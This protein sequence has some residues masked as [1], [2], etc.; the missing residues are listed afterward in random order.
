MR[1]VPG[2]VYDSINSME[3]WNDGLDMMQLGHDGIF[4][5]LGIASMDPLHVYV[6]DYRQL[7]P[8]RLLQYITKVST[9]GPSWTHP[10]DLSNL[11]DSR[12]VVDKKQLWHPPDLDRYRQQLEAHLQE[13]KARSAEPLPQMSPKVLMEAR[14]QGRRCGEA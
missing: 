12:T 7:D 10:F 11:P 4:R 9:N 14:C 5:R 6:I 1:Y 2:D 13:L 8:D 3:K